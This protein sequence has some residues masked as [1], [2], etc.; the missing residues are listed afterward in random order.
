MGMGDELL[1][2]GE[3]QRV[4]AL[5]GK[6]VVIRDR[7]GAIREHELWR[8]NPAIATRADR[9]G[10]NWPEIQ[11]GPGVRPYIAGKSAQKWSWH[12][13]KATPARIYFTEDEIRHAA[14]FNPVVIIEPTVKQKASP[15]KDWGRPR[16]TELIAL[17]RKHGVVPYQLGPPGTQLLAGARLLNT[18]TFRHACAIMARA[19][20]GVFPEGGLHHGAAA[21]G[22]RSVVI[23]GGYISPAQTGYDMH[24]NLFTGGTPCG[25]RIPCD[26][27]AKAMAAITPALVL[28]KLT[29]LLHAA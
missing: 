4:H 11:N 18:P 16:W 20:V 9:I 24:T 7:N 2:A 12:P 14:Q 8:G 13:F 28:E 10:M 23:Y 1:A 6:P 3:A 21:V 26:H 25:M 29:A 22:L 27:C 15:N 17:L 19:K 5:R